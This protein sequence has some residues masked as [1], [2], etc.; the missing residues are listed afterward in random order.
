MDDPL[1][2]LLAVAGPFADRLVATVA[3]TWVER[4]KAYPEDSSKHMPA[5]KTA[6]YGRV[7]A[8]VRTWLGAPRLP[9]HVDML[10][11]DEN[12]SATRDDA[13]IHVSVP[14]SWIAEVWA[15]GLAVLL[16][17]L[18]LAVEDVA[19][20]RMTLLAVSPD[21][22]EPAPVTITVG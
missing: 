13:G 3:A 16:G 15:R 1:V 14:F 19:E 6:L 9:L 2:R 20:N 17:R 10:G 7:A 8:S 22:G 18:V 4:L 12:P 11:E 5:L 21:F